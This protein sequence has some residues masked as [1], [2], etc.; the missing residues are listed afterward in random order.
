MNVPMHRLHIHYPG[1]IM[2]TLFGVIVGMWSSLAVADER[3]LTIK[4]RTRVL[5]R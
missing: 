2:K 4:P 5:C 1:R 3:S